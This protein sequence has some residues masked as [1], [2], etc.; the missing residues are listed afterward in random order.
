MQMIQPV[1]PQATANNASVTGLTTPP[2]TEQIKSSGVK[3]LST[4][5]VTATE[6]NNA[7]TAENEN[8]NTEEAS[9]QRQL[10][11]ARGSNL[12]ILV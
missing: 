12:D 10:S 3:T 11:S 7:T 9:V 5:S 1:T 8:R 6:D 4:N 2:P